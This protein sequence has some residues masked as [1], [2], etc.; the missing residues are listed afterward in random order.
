M[1][2]LPCRVVDSKGPTNTRIYDVAVYFRQERL[3]VGSGQSIQSAEMAAAQAALEKCK[4]EDVTNGMV[5][6]EVAVGML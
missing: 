5:R 1:L 2:Y 3:A 4:G 6:L